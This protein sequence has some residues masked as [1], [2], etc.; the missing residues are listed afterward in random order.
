MDYLEHE[1]SVVT[2]EYHKSKPRTL[3]MAQKALIALLLVLGTAKACACIAP[4]MP[5]TVPTSGIFPETWICEN[6]G[7][8]NYEGIERCAVCGVKK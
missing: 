1:E 8:D 4:M 5:Y 6:C 7:Y 3:S 2:R